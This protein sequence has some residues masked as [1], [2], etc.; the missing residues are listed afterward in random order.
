MV[1]NKIKIGLIFYSKDSEWKSCNSIL[2]NLISSYNQIGH[3]VVELSISHNSGE[4]LEFICQKIVT[5]KI[6]HLVFIDHRYAPAMILA[7]LTSFI[8][9]LPSVY[10]HIYGDFFINAPQWL[11]S[12]TIL[13][14]FKIILICASS[15]QSNLVGQFL[16][17]PTQN[18]TT[19]PFPV[20]NDFSFS[21]SSRE[22]SRRNRNF[23]DNDFVFCYTGRI[24]LQKNVIDAMAI[25][26]F[27]AKLIPEAKLIIAGSFDD[28]GIPYLGYSR[29]PLTM[30]TEFYLFIESLPPNIRSRIIYTGHLK[31]KD[32]I[33][34]YLSSDAYISCSTHNDEDFGMAPA[35]AACCGLPL[36]LSN[37]GGFMDFKINLPEQVTLAD[38][39]I[40]KDIIKPTFLVKKK[41]FPFICKQ[42]DSFFSQNSHNARKVYSTEAVA[43]KLAVLIELENNLFGGFN[44]DF[45]KAALIP[46]SQNRFRNDHKE[47]DD[48]YKKIYNCYLNKGL[49]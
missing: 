16:N 11:D 27:A 3:D 34:L 13:K 5:E 29:L 18:L 23:S 4:E 26:S 43:K 40:N 38:V 22:L 8:Q 32:L 6:S 24:S 30:E 21:A 20:N 19:I 2:A 14:K 35:E 41:I 33:D 42:D 37:W 25:F 15:A 12:D 7:L 48:N 31:Q 44:S 39:E 46:I 28:I 10:I 47:F 36:F 9:D 49:T 17:Y 45:A 1:Q